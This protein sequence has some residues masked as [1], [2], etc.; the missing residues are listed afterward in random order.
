MAGGYI[1][2]DMI[3]GGILEEA[4]PETTV[5]LV[6]DHGFHIDHLRPKSVPVE[7]AGPA[8]QHRHYGIFA[9]TGPGIR[10]DERIYGAS[11]LDVVPTVLTLFGLPPGA[12]M[13]GKV[14]MDAFETP[15]RKILQRLGAPVLRVSY[16]ENARQAPGHCP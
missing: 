6:S 9:M 3:L 13:D 4:G 8:V 5:L 10:R 7:P 12:D 15:P 16:A 1:L 11:L 2:H 14:L